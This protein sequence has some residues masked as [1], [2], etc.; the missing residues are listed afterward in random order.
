LRRWIM[1]GSPR[2]HTKR[3]H[4]TW[5]RRYFGVS[6]KLGL[7]PPF[8]YL[9]NFEYVADITFERL[10]NSLQCGDSRILLGIFQSGEGGAANAQFS[11]KSGL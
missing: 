3:A 11:G 1:W 7:S 4:P 2:G 6:V 9:Q 5:L 10:T 8:L